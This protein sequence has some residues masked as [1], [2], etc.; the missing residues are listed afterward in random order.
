MN[1]P[2][3]SDSENNAREFVAVDNP[4]EKIASSGEESSADFPE[5]DESFDTETSLAPRSQELY[6]QSMANA[7][8]A[9]KCAD[10]MRGQNIVLLD[11][12]KI[13]SFVDFFVISTASSRRQMHAIADAVNKK[14]KTEGGNDRLGIEGYRTEANWILVDFGDVVLHV[15]T[16]EGRELYDLENLKADAERV[17][18]ESVIERPAK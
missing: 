10:E 8:E 2:S 18:W 1:N 17:D 15:F 16:P 12:T 13:A 7:L 14:L 11:L 9:V 3:S 6:D 5:V 4:L